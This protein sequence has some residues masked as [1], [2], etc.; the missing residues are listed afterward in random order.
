M[1]KEVFNPT[2]ADP[3]LLSHKKI[4]V[5]G[6]CPRCF[7][8]WVR[9]GHPLPSMPPFKLNIVVDELMKRRFDYY[10][11]RQQSDPLMLQNGVPGVP[12]KHSKMNA[13]RRYQDK[14][15]RIQGIQCL[16][17][18]TNFRLVGLI[19]EAQD[20]QQPGV[21]LVDVKAADDA[22]E[23]LE[24]TYFWKSNM[25]QMDVY[26]YIFE[27]VGHQLGFTVIP[28][29]YFVWAQAVCGKPE[30]F[31]MYHLVSDPQSITVKFKL[32]VVPY[33]ASTAWV[34]G[35]LREIKDCLMSDSLPQASGKCKQCRY[36]ERIR[37]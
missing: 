10:R 8:R 34:E 12:F 36:Q 1:K 22:K 5:F 13:W 24:Q 32:S 25:Q 37:S 26:T 29:T 28:Q 20:T 16:H 19:D 35:K 21:S 14:R 31:D 3:F 27:R 33:L 18:E 30:A 2:S 6:E 11:K 15:R 4:Q 23:K 9:L 7:Y 17:Q